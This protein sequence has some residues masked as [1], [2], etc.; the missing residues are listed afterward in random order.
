MT[1]VS[2][3][4]HNYKTVMGQILTLIIVMINKLNNL[5][6]EEGNKIVPFPDSV[7]PLSTPS[8]RGEGG[9]TFP[10]PGNMN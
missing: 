10:P 6:Q 2:W 4:L 8:H 9:G 7:P 3:S 5:W 1:M